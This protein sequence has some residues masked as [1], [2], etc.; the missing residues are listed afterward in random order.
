[1]RKCGNRPR[2]FGANVVGG[3]LI[4]LDDEYVGSAVHDFLASLSPMVPNMPV[5]AKYKPDL[6]RS[7]VA[8]KTHPENSRFEKPI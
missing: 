3:R 4:R 6:S 8:A 7:P 2:E 5:I 1:M